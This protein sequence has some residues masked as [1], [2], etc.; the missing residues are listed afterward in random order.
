ML[1]EFINPVALVATALFAGFVGKYLARWVL[2]IYH[3]FGIL[4]RERYLVFYDKFRTEQAFGLLSKISDSSPDNYDDYLKFHQENRRLAYRTYLSYLFVLLART[5]LFVCILAGGCFIALGQYYPDWV[6]ILSV[7]ISLSPAAY[8]IF[9]I[10]VRQK[11]GGR[12]HR[13]SVMSVVLMKIYRRRVD[14]PDI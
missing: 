12:F 1:Q 9:H 8:G 6:Y 14:C 4:D 13:L 10:R 5:L 7:V 3:H 11:H 2:Q